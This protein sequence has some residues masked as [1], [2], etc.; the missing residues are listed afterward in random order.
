[1]KFFVA[2]AGIVCVAA[3][4][5]TQDELRRTE[6]QQG[7]AVQ[8]LRAGAD[9]SESGISDLRTEIRRTQESVHEL[10]VVL[11]DARARTDA[12]KV[13]A[14]NALSTSRE[15][16]ANLIAA[17]E[18]QRR[19]LD[20]NGVAF[21]DLRRKLAELESQLQAQQRQL[22]QNVSAL[23]DGSR[24]LVAVEAG[25]QEAG[26]RSALL[27]V[28]GKTAQ[29]TND[30]LTRQLA[31]VRKQVEDTRS[32]LSSEGLLQMMRELE[33]VRRNSASLRGS[34]EELQKAQADSAAQARNYYLD[35]DSRVRQLKQP[36]PQAVDETESR[37]PAASAPAAEPDHPV[38][39]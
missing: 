7:Q 9:R 32:V 4:C 17:R 21:A 3:G 8:A 37:S 22:E 33:G 23:N 11:T 15:F 10:E 20:E 13:Q 35:L 31:T 14:D 6:A 2:L 36:A 27:E 26:R 5:A 19:Q 25:L 38:S 24:R 39:Q 29:E 30:G 28:K 1:M 34:I 12:A 18:E 16:L